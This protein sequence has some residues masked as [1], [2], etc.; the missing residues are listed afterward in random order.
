MSL[1]SNI[2][3]GLLWERHWL[4]L[5][6][7]LAESPSWTLLNFLWKSDFGLVI[8]VSSLSKHQLSVS[9]HSPVEKENF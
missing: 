4:L 1:I 7:E 5:Q 8:L 6:K 9:F 3:L 2:R